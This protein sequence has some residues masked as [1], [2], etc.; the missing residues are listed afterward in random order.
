MSLVLHRPQQ[1]STHYPKKFRTLD[2]ELVLRDVPGKSVQRPRHSH[3]R[4]RRP[5]RCSRRPLGHPSRHEV[6]RIVRSP[7]RLRLLATRGLALRVRTRSLSIAHPR[8]GEKPVTT[9][10]TRPLADHARPECLHP[11]LPSRS[12]QVVGASRAHD[13]GEPPGERG[14]YAPGLPLPRHR[15][16]PCSLHRTS[17]REHGRV[18]SRERRSVRSKVATSRGVSNAGSRSRGAGGLG[19]G[20]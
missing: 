3:R 1:D 11:S 17:F 15:H 7:R 8:I 9:L 18:I 14:R 13:R 4:R 20:P 5:D 19:G 16:R 10:R 12:P 2:P 6:V